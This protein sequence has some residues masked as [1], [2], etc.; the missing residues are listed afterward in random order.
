MGSTEHIQAIATAAPVV[1]ASGSPR[2]ASILRGFGMDFSVI[3]ANID[4]SVVSHLPPVEEAVTLATLKVEAVS[5]GHRDS[6][7]IAA[8]TVVDLDGQSIGKPGDER[9]AFAMLSGL[10]GRPHLVHTGVAVSVGGAVKS[11]VTTTEVTMRTLSATEI[12]SYI[13]SG[14]VMD[15]AGAYGIQDAEYS[16]VESIK[17]SYLNVVGLPVG[18]LAT[19]L[20]ESGQIDASA[21]AAMIRSDAS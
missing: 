8:D 12:A 10:S 13:R 2:R 5:R 1:L 19:L 15:K 14:L 11:G 4:E 9:Q 20:Y 18:L 17:G 3:P 16:P 7:V 6:L 21:Q